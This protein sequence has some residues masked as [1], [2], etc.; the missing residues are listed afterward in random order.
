MKCDYV[1]VTSWDTDIWLIGPPG[2]NPFVSFTLSCNTP[3]RPL[4]HLLIPREIEAGRKEEPW[5][6]M[7]AFP[8][9]Y[10]LWLCNIEQITC[11]FLSHH[12]IFHVFSIF[13]SVLFP[14]LSFHHS[15]WPKDILGD[16]SFG[17]RQRIKK[18]KIWVECGTLENDICKPAPFYE[19]AH[20]VFDWT[21]DCLHIL[22]CKMHE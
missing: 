2:N 17:G 11:P 12:P 10:Q 18:R 9:Q 14:F 4:H 5:T 3:W 22:L 6:R 20:C 19:W 15:A 16:F 13:C 1:L 21:C 7:P 8:S